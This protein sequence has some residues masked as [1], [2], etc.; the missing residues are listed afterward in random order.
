MG[1]LL[2]KKDELAA[3]KNRFSNQIIVAT[4]GCFDMLHVGHTRYLQKAKSLGDILVIGVNS[5]K[6]VQILKGNSRPINGENERAEILN[7]LNCVDYTFIFDESDASEFLKVLLP[8]KYVK[9]GDYN[10]E[11]LPESET[12][13]L[14]NSEIHFIAFEKGYSTTSVINRIHNR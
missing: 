7:A 10:L 1:I 5:D 8:N 9:G 11:E 13:K 14:I 12:V 6:S 2:Q 3:I 4:N